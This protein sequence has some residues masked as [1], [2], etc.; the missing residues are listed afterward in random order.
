MSL[1]VELSRFYHTLKIWR[2]AV[3]PI[4]V[5]QMSEKALFG[6]QQFCRVDSKNFVQSG[7]SA[8]RDSSGL[9]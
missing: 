7:I 1:N 3:A 6:L 8:T 4:F 9:P 2:A 5:A